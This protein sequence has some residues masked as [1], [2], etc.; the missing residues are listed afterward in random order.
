M[1]QDGAGR[2]STGIDG[3]HGP[4]PKSAA[5]DE[6]I[7][8]YFS[9]NRAKSAT[10][11]MTTTITERTSAGNDLLGLNAPIG[12][13]DTNM[14][15]IASIEIAPTATCPSLHTAYLHSESMTNPRSDKSI[16]RKTPAMRL[17]QRDE[18]GH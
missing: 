17:K 10:F 7:C 4:V 9:H 8:G 16:A 12:P 18:A 13:S 11:A 3:R 14:S 5:V 2:G 15:S 1:G 6:M